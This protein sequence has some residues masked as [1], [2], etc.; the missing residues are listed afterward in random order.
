MLVMGMRASQIKRLHPAAIL[1]FPG[2]SP[3][4]AIIRN[5]QGQ[6]A[7]QE[8]RPSFPG[9][10]G[11]GRTQSGAEERQVRRGDGGPVVVFGNYSSGIDIRTF[12]Q[13]IFAGN[14]TIRGRARAAVAVMCSTAA[15]RPK[16]PSYSSL[17]VADASDSRIKPQQ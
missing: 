2:Q 8:G 5:M 1:A 16:P 9:G 7:V 4:A 3:S 10:G 12:A 14:N 13:G 11:S 15:F 17:S 6:A